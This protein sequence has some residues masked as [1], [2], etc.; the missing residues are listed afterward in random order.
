MLLEEGDCDDQ[1]P[2]VIFNDLFVVHN[3]KNTIIKTCEH[4]NPML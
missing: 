1:S 3:S 2:I 4:Q